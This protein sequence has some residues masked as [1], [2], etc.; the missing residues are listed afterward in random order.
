MQNAH[1]LR[2]PKGRGGEGILLPGIILMAVAAVVTFFVVGIGNDT[3]N[4][5]PYLFLMP[6]IIGLGI[7]MAIPSAILYYQ[8]KFSLADPIVF[9][10]WSYLFP[11][12][13]LGGFFFSAGWSQPYFI[14]YIQDAHYNLPLTVVLIAIGFA[15]LSIGYFLPVGRRL[16]DWINRFLPDVKYEPTKYIGPGI[17]LLLL[18]V[19]NTI[20][21]FALG[22]FGYQKADEINTYDGLIY[23]TTL[24]WLQASFLL[25]SVLFQKKTFTVANI[26]VVTLLVATAVSKALFA[27]NRG[28]LVQVFMIVVL[29]YILSGRKLGVKQSVFAGFG[30]IFLLTLGMIY[31]TTFRSIKGGESQQNF[32]EYADN[33]S[34]TI[35]KIEK[36]DVS[37]TLDTGFSSLTERIDV[38]STVAVVVSNYEALAPYEEA[39]D[40]DNNIW[41]D[42]TT[43]LV[44]RVVWKEKPP[45]S[46]P[47]KFSDLYFNLGDNSFAITPIGDLLRNYGVVG[48]PIGMMIIGIFLRVFYRT[49]I[50]DQP[51]NLWRTT[52]YFMLIT[53][54]SY[55]AFYGSLIPNF[56]KVGIVSVIGLVFVHIFINKV[57]PA[58]R[59]LQPGAVR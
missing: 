41:K 25:W 28:S 11:A 34:R 16:G 27:G 36:S 4:N 24:F 46:D 43:S 54:L 20:L 9:S 59:K 57:A 47:R 32:D 48:L 49:L 30:L 29:A 45:L 8:G 26:V 1:N 12:F 56:F 31:G 33:V 19:M 13:V 40:L 38:L 50:E 35:D 37:Q 18:G 58:Q 17:A 5:F 3:L 2:L 21:A 55:E 39:Y 6:W 7:V 51:L 23:F 53:S 52:L 44:P 22:I 10:T 15:G 14:S 42:T